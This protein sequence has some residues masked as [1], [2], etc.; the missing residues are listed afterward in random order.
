M[1]Q[2]VFL[3]YDDYNSNL[4][5]HADYI[6]TITAHGSGCKALRNGI[7]IIEVKIDDKDIGDAEWK[8][9][10]AMYLCGNARQTDRQPIM[11]NCWTSNSTTT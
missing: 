2:T 4:Y 7:K 8:D 9:G 10:Q 3:V 5:D 1:S 11:P 6:G